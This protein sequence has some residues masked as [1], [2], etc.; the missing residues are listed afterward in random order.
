M[1]THGLQFHVLLLPNVEW[2]ELKA[3][4]LRLEQLGLETVA[5][6]DHFVDWTNPVVPWFETWTALAAI[7]EATSTIRLT[8][9]VTQIP[10]RNPAML[11]RQVLTL[12]HISNGRI[13]L[14]LGTGLTIDPSYAMAGLP[15]W[16]PK[17]RVERFGEYVEIVSRLLSQEVTTFAGRF[18]SVE[19]AV[20]NPRPVQTPRPPLLVAALGHRMMQHAARFADT[21]NSMSFLPTFDEQL[22]ET[23]GRCAAMS[24]Y[25]DEIGRSR[26]TLHWSYLM[27]DAQARP[28][29]GTI[30]YYESVDRFV[31]HVSHVA[32]LGISDIG[33]Y[34]PLDPAQLPTFERI[35]TDVLPHLRSQFSAS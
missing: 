30:S 32:E 17:E 22:D 2:A 24:T 11:A 29:G 7:A 1:S 4:A 23:R 6:A 28:K 33:L 27:F 8:T 25:C 3:R 13:E 19:G 12:D 26:S 14:G 16:T 20:M 5:L 10:L 31:D 9:V 18:Y 15:N 34:Y 21:W 35:A